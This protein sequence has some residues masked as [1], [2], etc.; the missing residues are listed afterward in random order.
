MQEVAIGLGCVFA[1]YVSYRFGT[2]A[3]RRSWLRMIVEAD[4][5]YED[6]EQKWARVEHVANWLAAELGYEREDS[7]DGNP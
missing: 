7:S 6:K 2:V 3:E 1:L 5:I 4:Q